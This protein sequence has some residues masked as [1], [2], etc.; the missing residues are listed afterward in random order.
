MTAKEREEHMK[1]R[2]DRKDMLILAALGAAYT[3]FLVIYVGAGNAFGSDLD[4]AAQHYAIPDQFRKLFYDTG[5]FFPSFAPNIG[6]GENIYVFSYYGLFSP[7]ILLSYLL[8]FVSMS[9]YIQVS[10]AVLCFLGGALFYR[11]ARKRSGRGAALALAAAYLCAAPIILHSHRHIMF[12]N[13]MPFVILAYEAVDSYFEGRRRWTL[14]FWSLMIIITSWF[15]SVSALVSVTLYGVYR[16]LAGTDKVT[17]PD[18]AKNAAG[19]ALRIIT[20]VMMAGVLLLP[21]VH[22]LTQGRDSSNVT[23][24]LTEMLPSVKLDYLGY[25]SYAMGMGC[26]ALIS[27][28]GA[29]MS[30][31]KARRFLGISLAAV[32]CIPPINYLLN[33]TMYLNA[34]VLIPFIPALLVLCA[35]ELRGISKKEIYVFAA[36][37]VFGQIFSK[38]SKTSRTLLII[39]CALLLTV[40]YLSVRKQ[41]KC[42]YLASLT[43]VPFAAMLVV[44][45]SDLPLPELSYLEAYNNASHQR[46]CDVIAQDENRWRSSISEYRGDSANTAP[47]TDFYSPYIYSSIHHKGYNDFYFN[48][49]NNENEFRNSALTTRSQNPFFEMYISNRYLISES[50]QPPYG[51][52]EAA[53]DG[54][55]YLY[56]S[57]YALPIGRLQLP[58]GEDVFDRLGDAEK[59]SAL[60][61]YVITG[62][63]GEYS[64][65]V[66]D[67]GELDYPSVKGIEPA[68]DKYRIVSD[69][70]VTAEISLPF[71]VSE[72][73][74]LVLEL[75]CDNTTG[76]RQ[77]ARLTINGIRNTLT[78]PD[79]KYYNNNTLFT[80]VLAPK[81][82]ESLDRL[83]LTFTAGD[84]TVTRLHAYEL[85][86]PTEAADCDALLIDKAAS[87]GDVIKGSI[88]ASNDG[89][90]K[91]CVPYDEGFTVTV[92]GRE[93]AYECV[94]KAFIGFPMTKGE[95]TV[96]AV[97]KAP[98]LGAGK[99]MSAAGLA[100]FAVL[101]GWDAAK[102]R[103]TKAG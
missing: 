59:M 45:I 94:D 73:R 6:A 49:M 38:P 69:E 65:A 95:H 66:T 32:I 5:E 1:R 48:V 34:K 23:I 43:L 102:R 10:S 96:E 78:H 63:G 29:V 37:F 89:W 56:R 18:L 46:L 22:V 79:W 42:L 53:R 44:N 50:G 30:K 47:T 76:K 85:P 55:L 62:S 103:K 80:Y 40:Y 81:Q 67:R 77:D 82:G 3:L 57:S 17:L 16:Y 101:I 75:V 92:D 68:G 36:A 12:V 25:S 8:P 28:I 87:K 52:S 15:F 90:F 99:L 31:D 14:T 58:L 51:Y 74:A 98:L 100:L 86:L 83:K 4:W 72:G 64:S 70:D 13:Y 35:E 91:L 71:T 11:F 19:F 54:R 24:S 41:D 9:V 21:T 2:L 84:F 7:V 26:F 88:T 93:Q 39:D 97:F 61:R 60:C 27:I 33:G 20:A